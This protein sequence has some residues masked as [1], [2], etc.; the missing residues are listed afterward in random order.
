M[1]FY[2]T[3]PRIILFIEII[4]FNLY[5]LIL[6]YFSILY[7]SRIVLYIF[8]NLLFIKLSHTHYLDHEYDRLTRLA[9]FFFLINFF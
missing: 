5:F 4:F 6:I 1:D 8:F 2:F 7:L 9:R 3:L